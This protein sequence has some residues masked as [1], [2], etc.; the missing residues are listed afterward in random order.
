MLCTGTQF[1]DVTVEIASG[2]LRFVA[3]EFVSLLCIRVIRNH[4]N[5]WHHDV[6]RELRNDEPSVDSDRLLTRKKS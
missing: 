4:L 5:Q 6:G 2:V 1:I 3:M